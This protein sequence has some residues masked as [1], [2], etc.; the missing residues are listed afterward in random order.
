MQS[1]ARPRSLWSVVSVQ[2]VSD[3]SP[4]MCLG[5]KFGL[6][7]PHRV[8]VAGVRIPTPFEHALHAFGWLLCSC[9]CSYVLSLLVRCGVWLFVE[10]SILESRYLILS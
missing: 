4:G 2:R 6:F 5:R 3:L 9:F 8:F 7:S 10:S 1:T